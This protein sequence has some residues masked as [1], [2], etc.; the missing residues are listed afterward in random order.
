MTKHA[1]D[2]FFR[3]RLFLSELTGF[4]VDEVQIVRPY[5]IKLYCKEGS[6][7]IKG[8]PSHTRLHSQIALTNALKETA[9]THT[10]QFIPF[11]NG[12]LHIQLNDKDWAM[13]PFIKHGHSFLYSKSRDRNDGAALLRAF[14]HAL[15]DVPSEVKQQFPKFL[16]LEKW[17]ERYT[18]FYQYAHLFAAYLGKQVVHELLQ[19]GYWSMAALQGTKLPQLERKAQDNGYL[20]HGDTA[21][22]NFIRSVSGKLYLIDFDLAAIAPSEYDFL[23]YANRILPHLE[24]SLTAL[25]KNSSFPQVASEKWFIAALVY[26][27]DLFREWNRSIRGKGSKKKIKQL[28]QW[29]LKEYHARKLFVEEIQAMIR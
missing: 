7:M 10:Y 25:S 28:Q 9:F 2:D 3:N 1:R 6:Y 11:A 20:I 21:E 27:T 29:T 23:Q 22:H 8:F 19:W 15:A 4:E 17:S 26:P 24:W 5:V 16:L 18:T 14:H 12:K 13:T